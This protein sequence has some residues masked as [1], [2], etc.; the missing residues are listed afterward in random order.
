MSAYN[1]AGTIR[2]AIDSC[3]NQTH[4][5]IEVIVIND[6]SSDQTASEL[7]HY[8][9]EPRVR[10]I[11]HDRNQGAGKSRRDGISLATGDYIAT[12]DSDDY[13]DTDHL[14]LLA[15]EAERL[16]ADIVSGGIVTHHAD[17]RIDAE[18]PNAWS[19]HGLEALKKYLNQRTM[20]MNNK[21]VR[22]SLFDIILYSNRRYVEDTPTLAMLMYEAG[23]VAYISAA[24][25]HYIH[26][27]DSLCRSASE[28]KTRLFCGLCAVD[29]VQYFLNRAPYVVRELNLIGIV[30]D[31][32][33]ACFSASITPDEAAIYC[34]E[35]VEF[36]LKAQQYVSIK[37]T[38]QREFKK[39]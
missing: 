3:L 38:T 15:A 8:C 2:R 35:W 5:D 17:G 29:L 20:F 1:T 9:N 36:T 31:Y 24:T 14:A 12:I 23:R 33:K 11:H 4:E 10:V 28:F 32:L 18:M 26:S 25:Y 6:A 7:T 39:L 27:K 37:E 22:R 19:G 13:I 30:E 34:N 21:I 16:N